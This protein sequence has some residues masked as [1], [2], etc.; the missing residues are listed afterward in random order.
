M[1]YVY[2]ESQELL[3]QLPFYLQGFWGRFNNS[4][5]FYSKLYVLLCWLV[6]KNT[7]LAL[8]IRIKELKGGGT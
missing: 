8:G 5:R 1:D 3:P 7:F 2:Q 6:N 4:P